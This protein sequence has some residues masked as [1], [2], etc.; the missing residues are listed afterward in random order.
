MHPAMPAWLRLLR[1]GDWTKNVFVLIA[2]IF[3][4]AGHPDDATSSALGPIAADTALAFVAFCLCASG[5]YAI[6]DAFDAPRD[7]THPVKRKR[8]VAAGEIRPGAAV[9]VGALLV[10]AGIGVAFAAGRE[11]G[12]TLVAYAILQ[13]L[14]NAAFKRWPVIDVSAV[15]IG[16]SLR[17]AC[18]ALA[19]GTPISPWLVAVVFSLTLYLGFIKRLCDLSSARLAGNAEWRS[20][21]GYDDPLELSWLLGLSATLTVVGYLTYALSQHAFEIFGVRAAGFA[22][23]TP[24]V[25]VAIFRFQRRARLGQSDS[26]LAALREDPTVLASIV[27]FTAGTLA[28]LYAPGVGETLGKL[29]LFVP[30]GR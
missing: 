11:A 22:L 19:I 10:A 29:F 27:L 30:P 15:A 28:T 16:F 3:W 14:Y 23:L 21:A 20:P 4:V 13:A 12:L 9:G 5:F 24:L 17:A 6:N 18:G 1:P 26:P 25:I 7:R 8:P 2:P